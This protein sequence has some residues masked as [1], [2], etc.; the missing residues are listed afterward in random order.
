MKTLYVSDTFIEPTRV[1]IDPI[2][3]LFLKDFGRV[4]CNLANVAKGQIDVK[5]PLNPNESTSPLFIAI[6]ATK[7]N[8]LFPQTNVLKQ[9]D[10]YTFRTDLGHTNNNWCSMLGTQDLFALPDVWFSDS[11]FDRC[12]YPGRSDIWKVLAPNHKK[13]FLNG[14]L[15]FT[16]EQLRYIAE[17]TELFTK[18]LP[19]MATQS[20]RAS[21]EG[22][23]GY[24]TKVAE[25][26]EVILNA[27][28]PFEELPMIMKRRMNNGIEGNYPRS[29]EM[30]F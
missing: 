15:E 11:F 14:L 9:E 13:E 29:K 25:T 7:R 22:D 18:C 2:R 5:I 3:G 26:C 6:S 10:L 20:L 24:L 21:N 8:A 23:Q 16:R 27:D 28:R 1:E 30:E 12:L 4:V 17:D 19:E